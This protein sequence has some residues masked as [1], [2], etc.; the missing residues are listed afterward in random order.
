M[1]DP[2]NESVMTPSSHSQPSERRFWAW[3][4]L[5]VLLLGVALRIYG[6]GGES[7]WMDEIACVKHLD[8]SSLLEFLR[9][10]RHDDPPMVPAYFSLVYLWVKAFGAS[11]TTAR[12]FSVLLS[13]LSMLALYRLA[14][15]IYGHFAALLAL[16]CFAMSPIHIYYSQEVRMYQFVLLVSLVSALGL[17]S[18][19]HADSARGWFVFTASSVVLM[20]TH[21]FAVF[22]IAIQG[23]ALIVFLRPWPRR[24]VIWTG[25]CAAS[26]AAL[27][28]W[29]SSMDTQNLDS[30]A[31]WI[32][33]PNAQGIH[34]IVLY[35]CGIPIGAWPHYV[36]FDHISFAVLALAGVGYLGWTVFLGRRTDQTSSEIRVAQRDYVILTLW[37]IAPPLLLALVSILVR[38]SFVSRYVL[39]N[40]LAAFVLFGGVIAALRPRALRIVAAALVGLGFGY[41]ALTNTRALPMRGDWRAAEELIRVSLYAKDPVYHVRASDLSP[42]AIDYH[43]V[44]NGH[45]AREFASVNELWTTLYGG[46]KRDQGVWVVF[47]ENDHDYA[48]QQAFAALLKARSA[49]PLLFTCPSARGM[50]W[51]YHFPP[52]QSS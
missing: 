44:A 38:P 18:A 30:L 37:W 32:P 5:V 12:V 26:F 7:V 21:L 34:N 51:L 29:L 27:V 2:V 48:R 22:L 43:L 50:I 19:L 36:Q 17:R 45:V 39:Y 35:S 14:R 47:G 25:I 41:M 23:L 8:A 4:A 1:S 20:W 31:A 46:P 24:L 9:L 49:E 16:F 6:I 15:D 10:E 28:A 13:A 42:I 52:T 40:N 33:T 11:I 3:A